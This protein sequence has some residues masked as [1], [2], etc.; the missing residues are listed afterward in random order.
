MP[1]PFSA[2]CRELEAA[3]A[4]VTRVRD[5]LQ[6]AKEGLEEDKAKLVG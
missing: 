3:L 5:E 2:P 1:L 4:E 6:K